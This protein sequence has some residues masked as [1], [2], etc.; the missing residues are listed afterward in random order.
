MVRARFTRDE[1][2]SAALGIVDESGLGA[3]SMRSLATALGTGPMTVYNYVAG[4]EGLEELV[5]AAVV[6]DVPVPEPTR[7]WRHDVHALATAM[8]RGVRAHPAAIP[9]VLTRRMSSATGFAIADALVDALERAGLTDQDRLY[10]FHAVLGFVTGAAQAELAGP[11]ARGRSTDAKDAAARIGAVAGQRFPHIEALSQV[12]MRTSVEDDFDGGLR[13]LLDG[14]ALRS[15][16][17]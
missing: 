7:D 8:W 5:V 13:M 14:I 16:H 6:A 3:L 12:A 15:G 1:I 17:R 11:L 10:A 2:A 4:K 9:L